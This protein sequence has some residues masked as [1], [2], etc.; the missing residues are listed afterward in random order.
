MAQSNYVVAYHIARQAL[1]DRPDPLEVE[2]RSGCRFDR[3]TSR[4]EVPY[5]GRVY[6]VNYPE[7]RV[8]P[9]ETLPGAPAAPP[10]PEPGSLPFLI[11]GILILH[12]LTIAKGTPLHAEWM[13]FRELPG[14]NIYVGPFTNRT[15]RPMVGRFGRSVHELA[16][17]AESLGGR[18]EQLGHAAASVDVLPRIRVAF[19]V[20]E[21]DEEVQPSGQILFDQCAPDYLD[22]EDLVVAAAEA[23]YAIRS[24]AGRAGGRPDGGPSR[25]DTLEPA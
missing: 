11:A 19:V 7:G 14:G 6:Y 4:F 12:Y 10:A 9:G 23:F 13:A 20:W 2:R 21:G 24:A 17:A 25:P 22:T 5:L 18:P 16:P 3:E 8:T 1:A 15:I